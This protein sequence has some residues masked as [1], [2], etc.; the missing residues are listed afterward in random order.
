MND[1][2]P[3][4]FQSF[5]GARIYRP[6][7]P[8]AIQFEKR[9][10]QMRVMV[11]GPDG[12]SYPLSLAKQRAAVRC[13]TRPLARPNANKSRGNDENVSLPSMVAILAN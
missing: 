11:F 3:Q 10:M 1:R 6:A 7:R 5:L 2:T 8:F 12:K 13:A 9:V 4:P